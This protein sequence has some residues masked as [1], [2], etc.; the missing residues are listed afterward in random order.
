MSDGGYEEKASPT[1]AGGKKSGS[2]QPKP[3]NPIR[4]RII[5]IDVQ[6][7]QSHLLIAA[8][9]EQGVKQGMRATILGEGLADRSIDMVYNVRGSKCEAMS[10]EPVGHIQQTYDKERDPGGHTQQEDEKPRPKPR[11]VDIGPDMAPGR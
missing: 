4:A 2:K 11:Y 3:K 9:Y 8:G 6:N 1:K 7:G 10:P 5:G